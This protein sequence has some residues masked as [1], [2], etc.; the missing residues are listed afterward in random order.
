MK[1]GKFKMMKLMNKKNKVLGN[2]GFSLVEL[3]IVIA[4]MAVLM[5]VL[6]PQ[7]IKY[8]E[9]SRI[10]AD[11]TAA[12]EI[13]N[14]VKV[15]ITDDTI[16]NSLDTGDQ[17]I[18]TTTPGAATITDDSD[19]AIAAEV[20]TVIPDVPE[21]KSQEHKDAGNDTYIITIEI[22]GEVVTCDGIWEGDVEVVV[23]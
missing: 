17:V 16:Y 5:A 4:I 7:L 8:V 19:A 3:I 21:A 23:P 12:S 18:W 1:E 15:A 20:L 11:N 13:L 10:Q 14:A 9:K 6:A 22:N 2:K